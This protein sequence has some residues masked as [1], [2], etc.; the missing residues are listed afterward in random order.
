GENQAQLYADCLEKMHGQ[1]PVMYYSN[2]YETFLWDDRFYKQARPVHGF[3]TKTEL[4][5]LMY[6]RKH[7]KDIRT[8]PIDTEIAGRPY[9]MR[10]IKSIAEHIAGNDKKTGQ[11]IGTN[12]GALLVLAT[13]TGK[14][15][16]SI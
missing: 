5:T 12:R 7:R 4:Q 15:R 8:A 16:T 11:L 13:G 1:R 9:Q 2:G 3:Y 14:T 10:S 6:R